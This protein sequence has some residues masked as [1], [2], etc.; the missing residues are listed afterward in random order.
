MERVREPV[1][2][3]AI[4]RQILH[5]LYEDSRISQRSLAAKV[6]MSAPAVAERIARL[7]RTNVITR[8]TIDVDWAA[9]GYPMLVVIPIKITSSANMVS[10]VAA[11]REI[12]ELT[13]VM[14]LAGSYDMM[15]RI[16]VKDHIDLQRLLIERIWSIPGLDRVETMLSLGK[17]ANTSALT[18]LFAPGDTTAE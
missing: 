10:V 5:H 16:R 1:D 17:I 18:R 9:L 2:L 15:A 11:L 12:P 8:H 6:G 7:E 4:D 3:D 13:E 14:V